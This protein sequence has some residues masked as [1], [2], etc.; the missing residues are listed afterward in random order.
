MERRAGKYLEKNTVSDWEERYQTGNVPWEKGTPHPEL[1]EFLRKMPMRGRVLVP[2]CGF[3]HDV[4][5]IAASADEVV[6][7][8]IAPSAVE[9]AKQ[10][11]NVGGEVYICGDLFN[12]PRN[13]RGVFDWV[14]EHTC[15]CAIPR[16]RREDYVAA[17]TGA[18][19]PGG[20]IFAVFY[21]NPDMDPGEQGPPFDSSKDELDARFGEHFRTIAEWTP[22]STHPGRESRE[23]CRILEKTSG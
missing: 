9:G 11:G 8:D 6:G 15:F 13:M 21:M 10:H 17:V 1:I 22:E 23:L 18:L 7:L 19:A 3:G 4:R 12:L 5:A 14:F 20:R 16:E 2:G